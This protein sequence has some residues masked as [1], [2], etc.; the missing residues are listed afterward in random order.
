[1]HTRKCGHMQ[2]NLLRSGLTVRCN[3]TPC[4]TPNCTRFASNSFRAC[5]SGC[6]RSNGGQNIRHSRRCNDQYHPWNGPIPGPGF[7]G[8]ESNGSAPLSALNPDGGSSSGLTPG[9]STATGTGI[10][11][12][13]PIHV[14]SSSEEE[15]QHSGGHCSLVGE[16]SSLTGGGNAT[17]LGMIHY[18]ESRSRSDRDFEL[19]NALESLDYVSVISEGC[20]C[21]VPL[22]LPR[23]NHPRSCAL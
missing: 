4:C 3:F 11:E 16:P 15:G 6:A 9:Q 23:A 22:G 5:C 13:V 17:Q 20:H 14:L 18:P 8:T 10:G 2:R 21:A 19:A 1:M 12:Q 7:G